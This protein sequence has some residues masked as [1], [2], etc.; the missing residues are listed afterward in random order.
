[1][2]H[3]WRIVLKTVGQGVKNTVTPMKMVSCVSHRGVGQW[4]DT[5]DTAESELRVS[6]SRFQVIGENHPV[7]VGA[8]TLTIG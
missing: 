5:W 1:M 2:A 8:A 3:V 4:W 7:G 6:G